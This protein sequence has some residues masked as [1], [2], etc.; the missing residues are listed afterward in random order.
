MI[1]SPLKRMETKMKGLI[2]WLESLL[3]ILIVAAVVVSAKD[4]IMLIYSVLITDAA[5]SYQIFQSL[6]SHILLIVVGLELALM[7]ISHSA[8]NVIE[9]MLYAIARKMLISSSNSVDVLLGVIA[10]ALVFWVD[11]YLHSEK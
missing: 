5:G 4:I 9:V 2:S 6:L 11:K 3:A 1:N 8:A 10:L 7:L